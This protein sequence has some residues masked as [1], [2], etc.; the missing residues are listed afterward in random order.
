MSEGRCT[1]ITSYPCGDSKREGLPYFSHVDHAH[2]EILKI[3]PNLNNL[4]VTSGR[5]CPFFM[6]ARASRPGKGRPLMQTVCGNKL[7]QVFGRSTLPSIPWV[8][9]L[10]FTTLRLVRYR[11][12]NDRSVNLTFTVGSAIAPIPDTKFCRAT[13]DGK[14]ISISYT[15]VSNCWHVL[16]RW[17]FTRVV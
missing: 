3:R 10:I 16:P 7:S 1:P 4:V 14:S 5:Q 6:T 13:D 9:R 2:F 11:R 17:T 8:S 12:L 15:I